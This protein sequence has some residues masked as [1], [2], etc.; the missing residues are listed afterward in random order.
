VRLFTEELDWLKGEDL[1]LVM[2]QGVS[3]WLAW[4]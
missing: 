4:P 1:A 2:G 3:R